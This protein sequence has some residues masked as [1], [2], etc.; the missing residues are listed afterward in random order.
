MA[1]GLERPSPAPPTLSCR[2]MAFTAQPFG[3][4]M[5]PTKLV[6][7]GILSLSLINDNW[8][9]ILSAAAPMDGAAEPSSPASWYGEGVRPTEPRTPQEEL[10]GFHVP[11]GF[12]VRLFASEPQIAKPMN[13][14]FDQRGRVWVTDSFE[15]PYPAKEQ[16]AA[17]DSVR[18][19][20]DTDGD[21]SADKS[22]VF[23]DGLNIPI[24]VLPY[25]DGC[26][27]FSIP[28][29][30]YLRDT[31]GDGKCDQ[32]KVIL[33]P[34]DTTR[35]THGMINSLRMGADGWVYANHGFNNQS[36][37]SGR[38]GHSITMHSGNTF[39][40][41]PDGSRV[42]LVTSGQ[43]NPFGRTIDDWGYYYT[44][45][46][47]SKPISQLI[48]GGCYPSFGRPHD[49]LGFV[50]PMMDH[51]HGS[52]AISGLAFVP[53][54]VGILPLAGQM[55]S[56]NVMTSRIN[57]NNIVYHGATAKAEALP[58]FLT[59]DDPW[60]RPVDIRLGPDGYLYVAD[61]YNKIIGHYEVPLDHPGRDRFRG[62]IWQIRYRAP[63]HSIDR[64]N[65]TPKLG[66]TE[67]WNSPNPTRRR[68]AVQSSVLNGDKTLDAAARQTI[69]R[70]S[71]EPAE[72][73]S[74]Q[75]AI[76]ALEYL[77]QRSQLG[78]QELDLLFQSRSPIVRTRALRMLTGPMAAPTLEKKALQAYASRGLDDTNAHVRQ[79]AA[80]L[81]S[82]V[83][84][85]GLLEDLQ[86]ALT[87][88]EADDPVLRQSIRIAIRSVLPNDFNWPPGG[89]DEALLSLNEAKELASIMLAIEGTN[90][91]TY[92]LDY[93]STVEVVGP[94]REIMLTHM[95]RH[96]PADRYPE[97][98][99]LLRRIA[100]QDQNRELELITLAAN[101]AESAR[102]QLPQ[103][104][105]TWVDDLCDRLL[106]DSKSLLASEQPP[107]ITWSAGSDA[108]WPTQTRQTTDNRQLEVRSSIVLGET[109][110]GT[111]ATTPF[112]CP[113][114][115]S[116]WL[117]GHNGMPDQPDHRKNLVQLV[118][119]SDGHVLKTAFP[120]RN[121]VARKIEWDCVQNIGRQVRL[122]CIDGDPGTAY[123]WLAIGDIEPEWLQP[124]VE[125]N[126]LERYLKLVERY[127]LAGQQAGL[128]Q[129]LEL[130]D[131]K[132]FQQAKIAT[133]L[134]RLKDRAILARLLEAIGEMS[135]NSAQCDTLIQAAKNGAVLNE[136][137]QAVAI[138]KLLSANQQ[139]RFAELFSTDKEML[140]LLIEVV[141]EGALSADVLLDKTLWDRLVAVGDEELLAIARPLRESVKPIAAE[142]E[143]RLAE[144]ATLV[145]NVRYDY[146]ASDSLFT[147]HCAVC[148]QLKGKGQVVGPQLDGIGARGPARLSEDI[149]VPD[150]NVDVAFRTTTLLTVSGNVLSGLIR[151]EN[152]QRVVIVGQDGKE[153]AVPIDDIDQR[154]QGNNSLMPSNFH[155]LMTKE[156][157]AG[158]IQYLTE[159]AVQ[160]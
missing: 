39:R 84:D 119:T 60:F 144:V 61:F 25:G 79:A 5:S 91:A 94:Q 156:E 54:S 13:L 43:V 116:F 100:G 1:T 67:D 129:L 128:K 87:E 28:N 76:S 138:T 82:K 74:T 121:D 45:D 29:I 134:A 155:E 83:G 75:N 37:V 68:L 124:G 57:R 122:E 9:S 50:P 118:D 15:Y 153:I 16:K 86:W 20:E 126:S 101:A 38:D 71:K 135:P 31:D 26:L 14:A 18:I 158:V 157:L 30:Y 133:Q 3:K 99:D 160:K 7:F 21:G 93:L 63:A 6:L 120:P 148:H 11:E 109:Y 125:S 104:L 40:F 72:N 4:L 150:R 95:I 139:R 49:G 12:E 33:G 27:C 117:A 130:A 146:Q 10:T 141:Q 152:D 136:V 58:D 47:H 80:E 115:I 24:G 132:P 53:E 112:E 142:V 35:D 96:L 34:F 8:Q 81:A 98:I 103:E 22:S 110:T 97:G 108:Q 149:L 85:L 151:D 51:Q 102:L 48:S 127:K 55:L 113:A 88:A 123:A 145:G 62:R 140:K 77:S 73:D 66:I 90:A 154:R 89:I 65:S 131:N 19:L 105:M 107:A 111:Y 32:Q 2:T 52:T 147:K 137:E 41:L 17:K 78:P 114:K 92:L 44:A 64:S 159:T 106:D 56:G 42:E 70:W 59:S 23:A 143:K 36:T 46:C 69:E